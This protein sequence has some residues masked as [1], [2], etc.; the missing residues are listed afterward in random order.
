MDAA[1]LLVIGGM[2]VV[3]VALAFLQIP[4]RTRKRRRMF[5]RD[6][7]RIQLARADRFFSREDGE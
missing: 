2:C 5:S 6:S 3:F 1:A 7:Y 4:R